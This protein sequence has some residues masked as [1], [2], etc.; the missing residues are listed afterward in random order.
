M[1]QQDI[2]KENK[3]YLKLRSRRK[4]SNRKR[5]GRMTKKEWMG[6]EEKK[7]KD[8]EDREEE[9]E[10]GRNVNDKELIGG[11]EIKERIK[12]NRRGWEGT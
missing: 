7:G 4:R 12:M 6:E 3:E 8:G 11:G 10:E 9:E 2:E 1:A 5:K